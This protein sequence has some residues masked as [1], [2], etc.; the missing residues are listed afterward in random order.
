MEAF[1]LG[2]IIS[3]CLRIA[4]HAMG[5]PTTKKRRTTT[6]KK[7]TKKGRTITKTPASSHVAGSRRESFN[8]KTTVLEDAGFKVVTTD[9]SGFKPCESHGCGPMH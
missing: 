3:L 5:K 1:L 7:C 4:N 2:F 6:K 9:S 8:L